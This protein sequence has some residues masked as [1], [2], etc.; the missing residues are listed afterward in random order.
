MNEHVEAQNLAPN[1]TVD[2]ANIVASCKA[3]RQCDS[4]HKG[5]ALNLTP[6]MPECETELRFMLSGRVKG[7]TPRATDAIRVLNLGDHEENNKAL[8]EKRKN[9][10][11]QLIWRKAG[12]GPEDLS[13]EDPEILEMLIDDLS[14]PVD[15][16]LEGF[17]PVL[18]NIL[19]NYLDE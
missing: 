13:I 14:Q 16:R 15:G 3:P 6:L 9:L 5:Q 1:R 2:F 10:V 12:N 11:E 4:A 17:A 19:R 8:I 18:V 7:K